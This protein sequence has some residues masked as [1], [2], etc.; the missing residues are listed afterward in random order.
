MKLKR[1]LVHAKYAEQIEAMYRSP[2]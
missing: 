1:K 2:G